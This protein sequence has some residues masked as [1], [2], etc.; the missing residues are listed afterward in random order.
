MARIKELIEKIDKNVDKEGNVT[1][2]YWLALEEL[3]TVKEFIGIINDGNGVAS[4]LSF[5]CG[6]MSIPPLSIPSMFFLGVFY[7]KTI[8]TCFSYV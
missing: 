1:K 8:L 7:N 3:K 6:I 4:S 5:C 2:E